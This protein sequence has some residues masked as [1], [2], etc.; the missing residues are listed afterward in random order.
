MKSIVYRT[1]NTLN[2]MFYYGIHNQNKRKYLGSGKWLKNAIKKHG[3]ENFVRRTIYEGTRQECVDF[4]TLMVDQSLVDNPQCYNLAL[5]GGDP[6][7]CPGGTAEGV[8]KSWLT[9]SRIMPEET[10]EKIR[11]KRGPQSNPNLTYKKHSIGEVYTCPHCNKTGEGLAMFR[12]HFNKCRN[13][14]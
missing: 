1:E 3:E 7:L 5:G 6:P 14:A 8:R 10:K 11:G 2:G 4:E 12:W 13:Y 9:R